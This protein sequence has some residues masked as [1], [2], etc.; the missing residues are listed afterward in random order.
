MDLARITSIG[1]CENALVEIS[2]IKTPIQLRLT[3]QSRQWAP[4][5]EAAL[6]QLL[7]TWAQHDSTR[8]LHTY[9]QKAD[10]P[11]QVEPLVKHIHGLVAALCCLRATSVSG[12]NILPQIESMALARLDE[13]QAASPQRSTRGAQVD[14]LCADH[15]SRG[16]PRALYVQ[17]SQGNWGIR[18]RAD[19]KSAA[20]TML[21]IIANSPKVYAAGEED[22][23]DALA[24]MLYETFRNSEEHGMLDSNQVMFNPC[25]RGIHARHHFAGWDDL[26]KLTADYQPL[27]SYF[28]T[29]RQRQQANSAHFIEISVFDSGRGFAETWRNKSLKDLE[30]GDEQAA[31]KECF[32]HG[33][34]KRAQG[35]G[36]GLPSVVRLL[37]QSRGFLRLRTGRLSTYFNFAT[38]QMEKNAL[39]LQFWSPNGS[40]GLP[41]VAGSLLTILVPLGK[42]Q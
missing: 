24:G 12:E 35:Y 2:K 15:L 28:H 38:M 6:I 18:D 11:K 20:R 25:I 23:V 7:L 10:D 17:N 9:V 13:Q 37:D 4:G 36:E 30:P 39:D 21:K 5:S 34:R 19:F 33:S 1:A 26:D 14:V 40:D 27:Q 31:V 8:F 22:A 29:I 41:R 32:L 16:M 3:T 42:F